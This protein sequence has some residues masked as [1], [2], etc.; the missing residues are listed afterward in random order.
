[1]GIER[2]GKEKDHTLATGER[3][4]WDY[5]LFNIIKSGDKWIYEIQIPMTDL[6]MFTIYKMAP[7]PVF[8]IPNNGTAFTVDIP[9]DVTVILSADDKYFIDSLNQ[10]KCT[11]SD[12]HGICPGPVGLIDTD[13]C[14]C[15]VG[16]LLFETKRMRDQCKFIKYEGYSPRIAASMGKFIIT[17]RDEHAFILSC[18]NSRSHITTRSGTNMLTIPTGCSLNTTDIRLLNPNGMNPINNQKLDLNIQPIFRFE[19]Q[20]PLDKNNIKEPEELRTN[21]R[22]Q[23]LELEHSSETEFNK[24]LESHSL[25]YT[26]IMSVVII[27]IIA[28][29]TILYFKLSIIFPIITTMRKY[30]SYNKTNLDTVPS[31]NV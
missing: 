4:F 21:K 18:N 29:T 6:P 12:T 9:V 14:D 16:L 3:N 13:F 7:F 23:K 24:H 22:L 5:S 1:M 2:L 31:T 17:S 30:W 27:I 25:T 8:P 28:A 26:L 20:L 19:K 10:E 11:Y 15:K